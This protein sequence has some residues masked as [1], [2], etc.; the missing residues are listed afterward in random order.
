M[1][2]RIEW[3][4]DAFMESMKSRYAGR[5][6]NAAALLQS[7]M[8]E[9]IG[10]Q[11]PPRSSPGDSPHRDTGALQASIEVNGPAEQGD[12]IIA[13]V[14]SALPYFVYL[15]QGTDRME[16]RPIATPSLLEAK[17]GIVAAI[18]DGQLATT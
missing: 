14:G 7:K 12:T 13:A 11:G 3:N 5:I 8:R 10:T 16:A 2:G 6:A 4:G 9:V 15:D 1:P 18:I 17:D